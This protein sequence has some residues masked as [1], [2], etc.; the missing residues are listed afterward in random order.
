MSISL[1]TYEKRG[2]PALFNFNIA[3]DVRTFWS[4]SLI[5]HWFLREPT[6]LVLQPGLSLTKNVRTPNSVWGKNTWCLQALRLHDF[7]HD[8]SA[9]GAP[10]VLH[11][12]HDFSPAP[13]ALLRAAPRRRG[14]VMAKLTRGCALARLRN[15]PVRFPL[16]SCRI[17]AVTY[18][19]PYRYSTKR[20]G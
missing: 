5:F 13:V 18:V 11:T 16:G 8:G 20:D 17:F 3:G 2:G 9:C 6:K 1:Q 19:F 7:E 15:V 10:V 14:P 4:K 12:V